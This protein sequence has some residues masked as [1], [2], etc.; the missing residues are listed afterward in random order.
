MTDKKKTAPGEMGAEEVR[1]REEVVDPDHNQPGRN[2]NRP[3][4][5]R[6]IA[7]AIT[8]IIS[9]R[10]AKMVDKKKRADSLRSRRRSCWLYVR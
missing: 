8:A 9:A 1:E 6:S 10:R 7:K 4:C 3:S 2:R 5:H